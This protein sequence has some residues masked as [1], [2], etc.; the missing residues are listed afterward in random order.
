MQQFD[1]NLSVPLTSVSS[2]HTKLEQAMREPL[3]FARGLDPT[4]GD[5]T[6]P[7]VAQGSKSD[8]KYLIFSSFSAI[9]MR[10]L[11]IIEC[12][13]RSS[14]TDVLK[15]FVGGAIQLHTGDWSGYQDHLK[16]SVSPPQGKKT[17]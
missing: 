5:P 9:L 1:A 10:Q 15:A 6:P 14:N 16:T 2:L 4:Y 12:Y 17:E 3:T 7:G 11:T 13:L 8:A